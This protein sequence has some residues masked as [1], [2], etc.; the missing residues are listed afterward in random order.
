MKKLTTALLL[1]LVAAKA[2]AVPITLILS[3][4]VEV[5]DGKLCVYENAQRS[6]SVKVAKSAPCY[7]TKTF[8]SD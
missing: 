6:E 2:S 3:D 7:H 1:C 4:E 5:P 8:D